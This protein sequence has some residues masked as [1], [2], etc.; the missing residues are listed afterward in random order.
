MVRYLPPDGIMAMTFPIVK[1]NIVK[2]KK[3]E[4]ALFF[5]MN[6]WLVK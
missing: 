6:S 5:L 2:P 4:N 3:L 1:N